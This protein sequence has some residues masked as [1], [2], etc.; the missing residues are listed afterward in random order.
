[1]NFAGLTVPVQRPATD[2]LQAVGFRCGVDENVASR[3]THV[4]SG[5]PTRASHPPRH[6]LGSGPQG[7]SLC[8]SLHKNSKLMC[9]A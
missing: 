4:K 6:E 2:A 1:M 9:T 3:T 5:E 8:F 7:G